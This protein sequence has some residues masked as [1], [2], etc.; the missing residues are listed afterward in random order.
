MPWWPADAGNP[1]TAFEYHTSTQVPGK[2]SVIVDSGAWTN[3]IG[4]KLA[5]Q[6]AKKA[7]A[8]GMRPQQ[9]KMQQPL[10][11][12]GVGNG[13]QQCN[14]ELHCP[15]AVTQEGEAKRHTFTAPIVEGTGKDLPGLLGLKS[16]E[17]QRGIIDT[18]G[19]MLIFPG[20]GDVEI[21]LPLGSVRIPLEKAPSGHLVMVIDEFNK[22]QAHT[23]GV[24][25]KVTHLLSETDRPKSTQDFS[26]P[27]NTNNNPQT[28]ASG[29]IHFDA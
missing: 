21:I 1:T 10:S 27:T 11:V 19:K 12:Q 26:T 2:C 20:P 13:S 24:Q 9:N 15:I 23:G 22:V 29:E 3:L 25:T 17:Q 6:L 8:A 14:W 16:L 7:I 18:G 4:E 28:T 5:R